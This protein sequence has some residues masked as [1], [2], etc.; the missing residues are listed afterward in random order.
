MIPSLVLVS[1]Y[2]CNNLLSDGTD[3][4]KFTILNIL[5][6]IFPPSPSLMSQ[7]YLSSSCLMSAV[8]ILGMGLASHPRHTTN[9]QKLPFPKTADFYPSNRA[10]ILTFSPVLDTIHIQNSGQSD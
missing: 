6:T 9:S 10:P 4:F 2:T 7:E 8:A 5:F 3:S 1:H